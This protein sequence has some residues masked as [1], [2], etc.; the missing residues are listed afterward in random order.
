MSTDPR[1]RQR[2]PRR[3]EGRSGRDRTPEEIKEKQ[4][5]DFAREIE[6]RISYF[7]D[8]DEQELELE[9]MNSY[10]RR[11]VHALAGNFNLNSESRGEDR[12]RFVCLVK[13]GETSAAPRK[14]QPAEAPRKAQSTEASHE[15][16]RRAQSAESPSQDHATPRPTPKVRLWDFGTQTFRIK[17]G[18]DGLRMALKVDGSIE[19]WRDAEKPYIVTDR[20]VTTSEFR[21]RQGKIVMPEEPGY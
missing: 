9:P 15:A 20:I 11:V 14:A 18:P 4:D 1:K 12:E 7:L 16:P 8:S 10:R 21:I 17:P 13:T 6:M 19:I 3:D 5:R 2:R